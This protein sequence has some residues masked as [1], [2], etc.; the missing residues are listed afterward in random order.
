[1]Y[2]EITVALGGGMQHALQ[3]VVRRDEFTHAV[4]HAP[5]SLGF[6]PQQLRSLIEFSVTDAQ[7]RVYY[8]Y[9]K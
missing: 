4:P 7:F 6:A 5:Q 3:R 8:L 1:M 2:I 9:L